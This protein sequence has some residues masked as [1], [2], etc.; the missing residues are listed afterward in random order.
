MKL[1]L[2][3]VRRG[4][5]GGGLPAAIIRADIERLHADRG[6]AR[7]LSKGGRAEKGGKRKE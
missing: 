6:I 5:V 1:Q 3:A 2:F 7:G 4:E